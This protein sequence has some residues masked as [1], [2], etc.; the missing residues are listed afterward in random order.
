L[1]GIKAMKDNILK[2]LIKNVFFPD[3]SV[4]RIAFGPLRGLK[5]RVSSLTGI[6]AWYGGHEPGLKKAFEKSIVKNSVVFDIGANWGEHSLYFSRL[7]GSGGSVYAFEPSPKV[8]VEAKW[9]FS[10]NNIPNIHFFEMA[11]TDFNGHVSFQDNGG[12][13]TQGKISTD[14]KLP[15]KVCAI[16]LDHFI[17]KEKIEKV[18]F[19]KIDVEGHEGA[20][21]KGAKNALLNMRPRL[22]VELHNP[23]QDKLVSSFL[24]SVNYVL[25]RLNGEL[26]K[27]PDATWPDKDGVFGIILAE[28]K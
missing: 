11:V 3:G 13:S 28:P 12:L 26:I 20:V 19:I 9:H 18:D 7:V 22:I 1:K 2:K 15:V 4:K 6:E 23:E 16:T 5:Y 14:D 17:E 25:K 27:N 21:L 10:S 24:L 8:A